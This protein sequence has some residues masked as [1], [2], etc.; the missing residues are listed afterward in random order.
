[1]P[2]CIKFGQY[3]KGF[4]L[5][6][7]SKVFF[8]EQENK[9]NLFIESLLYLS[10]LLNLFISH[11]FCSWLQKIHSFTV[12]GQQLPHLSNTLELEHIGNII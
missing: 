10:W 3:H 2:Q 12:Y 9:A 7:A 1:M 8:K 11:N 5:K 6:K 4:S